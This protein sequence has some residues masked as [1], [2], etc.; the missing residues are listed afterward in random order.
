MNDELVQELLR[1]IKEIEARSVAVKIGVVESTT[2]TTASVKL[3]GASTAYTGL[4][5]LNAV[6]AVNDRVAVLTFGTDMLV[7]GKIL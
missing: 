1:R 2:A 6:P 4:R 5:V 3:S 7:L